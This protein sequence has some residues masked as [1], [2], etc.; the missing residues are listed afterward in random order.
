MKATTK[1]G[2]RDESVRGVGW[3]VVVLSCVQRY[4]YGGEREL[5][6]ERQV[7]KPI[8]GAFSYFDFRP[9][10]TSA[11]WP[12]SRSWEVLRGESGMA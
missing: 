1:H 4:G 12:M 7:H 10:S 11:A 6:R 3:V 5:H 8:T 2:G 9:S